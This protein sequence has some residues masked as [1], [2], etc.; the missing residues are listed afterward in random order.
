M[1]KADREVRRRSGRHRTKRHSLK[2]WVCKVVRCA[3]DPP[4]KGGKAVALK[5]PNR[6]GRRLAYVELLFDKQACVEQ[7][8][9]ERPEQSK[10][11]DVTDHSF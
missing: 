3:V 6:R 1:A 4:E 2:T 11:A 5:A 9:S 7:G 10:R 8:L